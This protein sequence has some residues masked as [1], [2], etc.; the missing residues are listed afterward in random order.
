M[1]ICKVFTLCG[2][3]CAT[4]AAE[5]NDSCSPHQNSLADN[6]V[7]IPVQVLEKLKDIAD[8]SKGLFELWRNAMNLMKDELLK[9]EVRIT[10]EH[11]HMKPS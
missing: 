9:K 7:R 5:Q 4:L 2:L 3:I 8:K 11:I 1:S 6:S 10:S